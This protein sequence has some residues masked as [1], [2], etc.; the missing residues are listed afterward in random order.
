MKKK[1]STS[2]NSKKESSNISSTSS[3][4][5]IK[6]YPSN[7][8]IKNNQDIYDEDTNYQVEST[9]KLNTEEKLYPI[10]HPPNSY[11]E[12]LEQKIQEQAK[13]L[14]DLTNYKYLCEKRI[15]QLNPDEIF[16]ITEKVLQNYNLG[17]QKKDKYDVLY[18]KYTKLLR[19][20]NVL[21]K[22]QKENLN[23]SEFQN[24][25]NSNINNNINTSDQGMYNDEEL[26][27]LKMKNKELKEEKNKVIEL[28]RQETLNS[29]EQ[30]NLIAIL[31]QTI[32]NDLLKTGGI[33]KYVTAQN[34]VDFSKLKSEN[35]NYRKQ[36]V[37]SQA[38]VNSLKAE[39]EQLN[40]E[41]DKSLSKILIEKD[42]EN[43][44]SSVLS[45][46]KDND[47][48]LSENITLKTTINSQNQV[49]GNLT[50]EI[51]NLK[52]L[53][54]EAENK[55]NQN[56]SRNNEIDQ[57]IKDYEGELDS[58][59]KEINEYETKFDYFN[60][61]V[62][63]I[64]MS[65][66]K[67][68]SIVNQYINIYNKMANEDLNSLL[69]KTFS[70]NILKIKTKFDQ[71]KKIEKYSLD[72]SDTNLHNII[73]SLLKVV[74]NEFILIYE[75]VFESNKYY[76]ESSR[77]VETLENEIKA[78]NDCFEQQNQNLNELTEK[79]DYFCKE[80]DK[81]KNLFED[82]NKK[83]LLLLKEKD[84]LKKQF[85]IL[86]KEKDN[87]VNISQILIRISNGNN[88]Y[89]KL[90][91]EAVS[92]CETITKLEEEKSHVQEKLDA[93]KTETINNK[94][95]NVDLFQ[96]VKKEQNTLVQLYNEFQNQIEQKEKRL[97]QIKQELSNLGTF[98]TFNNKPIISNRDIP[99]VLSN[100]MEINTL[101]SNIFSSR[102]IDNNNYNANNNE[103]NEN[104]QGEVTDYDFDE[105]QNIQE[106]DRGF[107]SNGIGRTN[108]PINPQI[109]ELINDQNN[110]GSNTIPGAKFTYEISNKGKVLANTN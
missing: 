66:T 82:Y 20:F 8:K 23:Y 32:D 25:S 57:K 42:K 81:M 78:K 41:K 38:L 88:S 24:N 4:P 84:D 36:L 85:L 86:K 58:K 13:R 90:Y 100:R 18:N 17:S 40:G 107:S 2:K 5:K 109:N 91:Q 95:S 97:N 99:N 3:I 21:V 93:L 52:N 76:Q 10:P 106:N 83:N 47:I 30:K 89:G 110:N 39:I 19:D 67:L 56:V 77:K 54:E 60:D 1:N 68:Q 102:T 65:F 101:D 104:Y 63:N 14:S 33:N 49:I 9:S 35:D 31:Q 79:I 103:I 6:K 87:L 26:K 61:Y 105:N 51:T 96:M 64:K 70:E 62:S 80:N 53:I 15:I 72:S 71:L 69:T 11:V 48:L 7:S 74:N 46:K 22:N 55:I 98:T 94:G 34:V 29:E 59:K 50:N 28:L 45:V 92:L 27:K 12:K 37:L 75:K 108:K 16:P 43:D 73:M 44:N